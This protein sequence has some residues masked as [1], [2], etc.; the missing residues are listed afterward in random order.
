MPNEVS[1]KR[2]RIKR[3]PFKLDIPQQKRK[4][5]LSEL[6]E[7]DIEWVKLPGGMGTALIIRSKQKED[8]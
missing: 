5:L 3:R 2:S 8:L 7:D 1:I 6:R 4:P